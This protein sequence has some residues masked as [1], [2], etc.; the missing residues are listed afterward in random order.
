MKWFFPKL[1]EGQNEVGFNNNDIEKFSKHPIQSIVREGLQNSSDALDEQNGETQVKVVIDRGK[2]PK[3]ELSNFKEIEKHIKACLRDESNNAA[4]ITTIKRHFDTIEN[5][6][7]NYIKIADYHTSGMD[8]KSFKYFTQSDFKSEKQSAGSQGSKGVGKAAYFA[9]SY[10]RTVVVSSRSAEGLR[11]K[12]T[13]KLSTHNDP[14]NYGLRLYQQGSYGNLDLI[15]DDKVPTLFRRDEK[16]TSIFIMGCFPQKDFKD[17][18]IREVLRNYWFAIAK[19]QLVVEVER[20]SIN[21]SNVKDLIE[22]FF[23]DYR[24]YKTGVKQNPRPYYETFKYGISYEKEIANIGR[25]TLWLHKNPEFNLGAVARFRKTKMLIYKENNI[26]AGY[27]GV[28]L[29]DNQVG[30]EF[31]KNIENDA[32]D[33]WNPRINPTEEAEAVQ[34]LKEIKEFI[35]EKYYDY[36]GVEHSNTFSI[37]TLD[38]LF[39][40]TERKPGST[41]QGK[42]LPKPE[43]KPDEE[44]K[45][46]NRVI[47]NHKFSAIKENGKYYYSLTFEAKKTIK[48]QKLKFS[49]G[50]DSSRDKIIITK[51]SEPVFEEDVLII[52][53]KKG[54]NKIERLEFDSPFL[55]APFVTALN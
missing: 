12:A 17:D 26:D 29:C 37:N 55:V 21:S 43:P 50:T 54:M 13:A 10:L 18:V 14:D 23:P 27:A 5:D 6:S 34:T 31:L 8:G 51:A 24:D 1:N 9:S 30:N 25:C 3:S 33:E 44:E 42:P 4:E 11:F 53:I 39:S 15:E 20:E 38:E 49:I 28:F 36:A 32:H 2:I 46:R 40:F 41:E 22:E 52:D 7:Y 16:G 19:G 35:K 47:L 45:P 48:E